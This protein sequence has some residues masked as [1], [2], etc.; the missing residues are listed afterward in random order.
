VLFGKVTYGPCGVL[1]LFLPVR[2]YH[3]RKRMVHSSQEKK[4]NEAS[5]AGSNF[6][7]L[8]VKKKHFLLKIIAHC[9]AYR[10]VKKSKMYLLITREQIEISQKFQQILFQQDR[11]N[12]PE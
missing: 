7:N 1:L 2:N 10:T 5:L 11:S 9:H 12:F 3:D 6:R 4:Q 8:Y